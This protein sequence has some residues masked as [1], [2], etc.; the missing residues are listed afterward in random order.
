MT[1]HEEMLEQL[2]EESEI[3]GTA[4]SKWEIDFVQDVY[5]RHCD[6]AEY[7]T[8]SE[9]QEEIIERIYGKL[10]KKRA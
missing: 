9:K 4:M 1:E 2:Y 5:E 10:F 8:F 6:S 7:L 3:D